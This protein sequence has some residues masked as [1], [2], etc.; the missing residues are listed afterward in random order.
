MTTEVLAIPE[1]HLLEVIAIIR[2]G[3]KA[4]PKTT[5]TV[6]KQLTKWCNTEEQYVKGN[7]S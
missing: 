1:E 2:A 4:K 7:Q 3:I 6:K 5:P